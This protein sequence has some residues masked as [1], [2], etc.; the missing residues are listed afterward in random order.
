MADDRRELGRRQF[1]STVG[2][3]AGVAAGAAATAKATTARALGL[4]V[5]PSSQDG[6]QDAD[7]AQ[8]VRPDP[9]VARLFGDIRAGSRLDRWTVEAIH[10]VHLG[11]VPVVL[12]T[13]DGARFQVD[14]LRRD[15]DP[16]ARLGVAN[17][18]SLSVFVANRGDGSTATDEEQGLGA[19][20]LGDAL[21]GREAAGAPIPAL[22]THR[23]RRARHPVGEYS[24]LAKA[25]RPA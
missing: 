4:G 3:A 7:A 24:V 21:A 6:R 2:V 17:T 16:G 1:V 18:A 8:A 5:A 12:R 15:P 10:P 14:V 25:P 9:E 23:E 11:A 20:A 19:M 22:L 13:A